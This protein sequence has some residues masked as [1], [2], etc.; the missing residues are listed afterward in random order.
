MPAKSMTLSTVPTEQSATSPTGISTNESTPEISVVIPALNE[1]ENLE[2]LLPLIQDTVARLELRTEIIV[3]DGGS[4]DDTQMVAQKLGAR[5]IKQN[6]RGYGG[7]LLAG[8]AAAGGPYVVTMDADLSHPPKFL[9]DFWEQRQEADLLVASR[10]VPGGR[11]DMGIG[12]RILSTI[13]NRT[14]GLLL[15]IRLRDLSS[16]F[17]MYQQQ[18]VRKLDLQARD[19]DVLEEILVKIY[20][21]GGRIREVPFHYQVRN[22]GESHAKLIKFGWAYLKTLLRMCRLRYGK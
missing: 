6:E 7:A 20:V 14:Y 19:F 4:H 13:L 18:V 2:L 15:G 22:S 10:Y 12:R 3:V 9:K 11:A 17:R 21:A 8:F 5:V 1:Q 16:G